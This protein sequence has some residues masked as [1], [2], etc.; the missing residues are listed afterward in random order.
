MT[1]HVAKVYPTKKAF[2]AHRDDRT[3]VCWGDPDW[4]GV[5]PSSLGRASVSSITSLAIA[6][7]DTSFKKKCSSCPS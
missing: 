3:V 4:G 1:G 7:E 5:C 2:I 6:C